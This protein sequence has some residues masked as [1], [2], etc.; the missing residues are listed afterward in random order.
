MKLNRKTLRKM[1]LKEI[2]NITESQVYPGSGLSHGFS[3]LELAKKIFKAVASNEPKENLHALRDHAIKK[4]AKLL[5]KL[6]RTADEYEQGNI[7][8]TIMLLNQSLDALDHHLELYQHTH[9]VGAAS[10]G[11]GGIPWDDDLAQYGTSTKGHPLERRYKRVQRDN[12]D[13][14][15]GSSIG[16]Y[17]PNRPRYL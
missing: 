17:D 5:H 3:E 10:S 9:V 2:K 14:G 1:I 12:T 8:Q 16:P 11:K 7:K 15:K 6:S 13:Y 4:E